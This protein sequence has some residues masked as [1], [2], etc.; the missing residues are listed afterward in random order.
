MDSTGR[1]GGA[2]LPMSAQGQLCY[3]STSPLPPAANAGAQD[4]RAD[5]FSVISA[6]VR[7]ALAYPS[8]WA[9]ECY[10]GQGWASGEAVVPLLCSGLSE[11]RHEEE[12]SESKDAGVAGL[13]QT[14]GQR[15]PYRSHAAGGA[16]VPGVWTCPGEAGLSSAAVQCPP[17]QEHLTGGPHR[18]GLLP[19]PGP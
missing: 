6:G 19:S 14:R 8:P 17:C 11:Q 1:A 18:A 4:C 3:E 7:P 16:I 9:A 10:C 15:Q 5:P 2:A 12:D 13:K